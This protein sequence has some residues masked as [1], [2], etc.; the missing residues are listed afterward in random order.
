LEVSIAKNKKHEEE[1]SKQEQK[2]KTLE[3]QF[4][5]QQKRAEQLESE[6][7]H[8]HLRHRRECEQL[9]AELDEKKQAVKRYEHEFKD[10]S[11]QKIQMKRQLDEYE[12]KVRQLIIEF[13]EASKKHIRELAEVHDHYRG[14]KTG[15]LD[16]ESRVQ[17]LKQEAAKAQ[18]G[19]REAK[20]ELHR[21]R[22]ENDELGE[23]L[24]FYEQRY[25][26]LI[27]RMG[28]SQEDL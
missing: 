2:Y 5:Q 26:R 12:A 4:R 16:L 14:F 15:A 28:A 7:E 24:R 10:M 11:G 3:D 23:K 21:L 17:S 27:K 18:A 25:H 1:Q 22:L 20:K 8:L 6:K 9:E 13:E 19:E